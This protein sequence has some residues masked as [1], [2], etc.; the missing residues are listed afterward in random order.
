MEGVLSGQKRP[1][2]IP[3]DLTAPCLY[4]PVRHHSPACSLHLERT[5][6]AYRPDCV[7]V[8]GPE[9]ANHLLPLLKRPEARP[10]LALYYALRD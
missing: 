3:F 10:P 7:L 2:M 1:E 6:E 8:E 4:F 5:L 9:N